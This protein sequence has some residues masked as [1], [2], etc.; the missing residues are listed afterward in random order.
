MT[1]GDVLAVIAGLTAIGA[2]WAATI[3]LF[4]LAFPKRALAAQTRMTASPGAC[5]VQGLGVVV[6]GVVLALICWNA[7]AGPIRLLA[8]VIAGGIGLAAA[9]GSAGAVRLL[10]ERIDSVGT[11][12]NAFGS[13]TRASILYVMAG[14]LPVIGWFLILPGALL[15]SVG[16]VVGSLVP[17]RAKLSQRPAEIE[18]TA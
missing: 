7:A 16:S 14:F 17:V 4:A 12:M 5:L 9:V 15:L 18:V 2:A 8:G 3:L 6:V 11:P 10:G 13:L 1:I